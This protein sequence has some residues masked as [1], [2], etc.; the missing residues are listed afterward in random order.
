MANFLQH[1]NEIGL[2]IPYVERDIKVTIYVIHVTLGPVK[3]QVK[4]RYSAF[5]ALHEILVADHG[6]AKDLLPPKKVI[7]NQDPVFIENRRAALETYLRSVM[8]FLKIAMPQELA[9]FLHFHQYEVLYLLQSMALQFF[10]EGDLLL[11]NSSSYKFTPLQLHAI[12]ER[13]R[14]PCPPVDIPDKRLDLSHVLDFCWQLTKVE[15]EGSN[16]PLNTSNLIQ[17]NLPYN[18]S[19][20]KSLRH[21]VM[22]EVNVTQIKDAQNIRAHVHSLAVHHSQL[23]SIATLAM[24][25]ALHKD[26]ASAGEDYTWHR[27]TELDLSFNYLEEIDESFRLMAHVRKLKLSHNKLNRVTGLTHLPH[28]SEL[29]LSANAFYSIKD[30]HCCLGNVVRLDLSENHI[31][32]LGGFSKL[33]SLERLD[34]ARNTVSDVSEASHLSGLPNL[35]YLTLTG[36]PVSTTVD[37]RTRVLER[38]SSRAADIY[39]DN[40]RPNQ[41]EMDTIAI[42]Q[43]LRVVKEGR[44]PPPRTP[45]YS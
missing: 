11:Q 6:V 2:Q 7:G 29:S 16:F 34:L 13:L 38:L 42:L 30:L 20:F 9:F 32:T 40:E 41:K 45:R 1:R 18:L 10:N 37:Y 4:H 27:L 19:A 15:I 24:C 3:W 21:L 5:A 33:Y 22:T 31:S 28:L 12:S 23:R 25:D 44:T 39:L 8:N 43:V 36:N 35:E 17:N 26:V 14:Q